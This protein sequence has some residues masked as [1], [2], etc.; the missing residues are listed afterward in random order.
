[1][2]HQTCSRLEW[3]VGACGRNRPLDS[4]KTLHAF[5]AHGVLISGT[6][7]H[8]QLLLDALPLAAGVPASCVHMGPAM[9]LWQGQRSMGDSKVV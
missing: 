7:G 1:M 2:Q 3:H 6:T 4:M 8:H 9:M 5:S